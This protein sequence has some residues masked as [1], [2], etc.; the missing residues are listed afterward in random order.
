[1]VLFAVNTAAMN[2]KKV[3]L[4][5]FLAAGLTSF[6]YLDLGQYLSLEAFREHQQTLTSFVVE[7]RALS[8]ATFFLLYV[9][10]TALSIPG[11]A[12]MTLAAGAIFGLVTGSIL[13]SFASS[14][15]ATLAFLLSRFLLR[16]YVEK[17][18]SGTLEKINAGVE[19]EGGYY[20]FSLRLVPLFPFF[21]INLV[22]GLT[23]LRASTFYWVSQ[24]G[25]LAG[26]VVYVN[27]GTQLGRIESTDDILSPR[28]IGSFL[29]LGLF[30]LIAKKSLEF[31]RRART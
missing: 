10:I 17:K 18:F 3:L 16:E 30:P 20:L 1:M 29:L 12:V 23:R 21:A 26:T 11:A 28:L 7:N 22:M 5:A 2:K 9:A 6:L 13:V 31:V 4:L 19:K 25:M 27:A 8:L 15:G 14:I 24:L